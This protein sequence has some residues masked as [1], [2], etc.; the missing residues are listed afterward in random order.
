[1]NSVMN[2]RVPLNAGKLSSDLTTWG[3]SQVV[4]SSME[5]L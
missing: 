4:P 3:L 1:V 5:L 2:L